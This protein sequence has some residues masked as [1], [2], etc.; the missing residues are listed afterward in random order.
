MYDFIYYPVGGH[1]GYCCWESCLLVLFVFGMS[2]FMCLYLD[3]DVCVGMYIIS[4]ANISDHFYVY[5]C[6]C[7]RLENMYA[8]V[9]G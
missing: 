9:E 6:T 1:L 8:R 3:T 4:I 5:W 2:I 7:A